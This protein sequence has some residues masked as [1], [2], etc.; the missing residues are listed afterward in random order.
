MTSIYA[1]EKWIGKAIDEGYWFLFYHDAVYRALKWNE[2]GEVE[3]A[4][5]RDK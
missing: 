4:V 5:E 3:S 1:K 2:H